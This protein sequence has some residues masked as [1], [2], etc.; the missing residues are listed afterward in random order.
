MLYAADVTRHS[1]RSV[2][3]PFRGTALRHMERAACARG[4]PAIVA[5]R[6]A[7]CDDSLLAGL[8]LAPRR[9]AVAARAGAPTPK[10]RAMPVAAARPGVAA[11]STVRALRRT[12]ARCGPPS[13]LPLLARGAEAPGVPL[14]AAAGAGLRQQQLD[15]LVRARS[16]AARCVWRSDA[17]QPSAPRLGPSALTRA[18]LRHLRRAAACRGRAGRCARHGR[19]CGARAARCA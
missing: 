15:R 18:S 2:R 17:P 11:A 12:V 3:A 4:A 10:P 8:R 7:A 19:V 5:R 6:A 16:H 9:L 13:P 14:F 1:P